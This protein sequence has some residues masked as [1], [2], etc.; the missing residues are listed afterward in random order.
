MNWIRPKDFVQSEESLFEG[1]DSS[2]KDINLLHEINPPLRKSYY[3]SVLKKTVITT[4]HTT[5]ESEILNE[6][7]D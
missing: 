4:N 3:K 5:N 2:Q 1:S 6:H 7:N